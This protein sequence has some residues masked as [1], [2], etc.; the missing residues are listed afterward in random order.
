MILKNRLFERREPSRDAKL[1]IIFCEGK[2][3]EPDYFN[4]FEGIC[5]RIKFEI[6]PAE[7]E[8]NN[9]PTG[10][11]EIASLNIV[12]TDENPCPKYTN[13]PE[14]EIWFVI[15]TDSWGE[16]IQ[17]LRSLCKK[18]HKNWF[19][20]Q[21]NP[22]FEV[23]LYYHFKKEKPSFDGMES[24]ANWK[25]F[26]NDE[27]IPGGFDSRKHP[28]LLIDAI[29]NSTANHLEDEEAINLGCTEVFKLAKN[30]YPYVKEILNNAIS[31]GKSD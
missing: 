28:L 5:S 7:Q 13:N 30:F 23:W 19:I 15:D 4:Y 27:I 18:S 25:A 8:G 9:S 11:Y 14:D 21:S 22:C 16:K 29:N 12:Q 26:L 3:R 10:L 17:E 31:E 24:A 6:I 1:F 20:A 2:K